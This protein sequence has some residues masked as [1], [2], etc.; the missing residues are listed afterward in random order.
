[1]T[2]LV[3]SLVP[4]GAAWPT[5]VRAAAMT[6]RTTRPRS[7]RARAV[8]RLP[9]AMI[10]A[11]GSAY[12]MCQRLYRPGYSIPELSTP[13]RRSSTS[14]AIRPSSAGSNGVAVRVTRT[15]PRVS[16]SVRWEST[17][18]PRGSGSGGDRETKSD[19]LFLG[20][21]FGV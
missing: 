21:R 18:A 3:S 12:A 10:S 16:S 13:P 11:H 19:R 14:V 4:V 2:T 1:M 17:V 15:P 6:G 5:L 8:T 9:V 7:F 20:G